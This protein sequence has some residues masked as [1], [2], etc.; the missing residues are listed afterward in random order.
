MTTKDGAGKA[1]SAAPN[2]ITKTLADMAH[3]VIGFGVLGWNKAQVRRRELMKELNGQSRQVETRL[4]AAKEQ[5]ASAI[6]H[7]D[8]RFEP[9]RHDLDSR[10]D[11]MT[12]RLPGKAR[13]VFESARGI[14]RDTE[15]QVRQAI[16]AR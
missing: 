6:R 13:E 4:D 2:D 12:E 8:A 14:A 10:L 15:H 3:T 9:A 7:L 16:G 11:K 5:V 1:T